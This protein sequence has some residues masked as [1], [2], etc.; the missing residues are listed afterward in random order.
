MDSKKE[1]LLKLVNMAENG[2]P[3]ERETARRKIDIYVNK[4]GYTRKDMR[5]EKKT[6]LGHL[7]G[8]DTNTQVLEYASNLEKAKLIAAFIEDNELSIQAFL[9][10][11]DHS[12]LVR[13]IENWLT[14]NN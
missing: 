6:F 7:K 4:F 8:H 12:G 5:N 11:Y 3:Q 2:T 1:R 10:D 13:M 9:H 14:E